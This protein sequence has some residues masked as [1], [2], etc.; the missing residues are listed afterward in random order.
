MK[1][2][3]FV[4]F[5]MLQIRVYSQITVEKMVFDEVNKNRSLFGL[6]NVIP[7]YSLDLAAKHHTKWMSLVGFSNIKKLMEIGISGGNGSHYESIDVPNFSELLT[8]Q[9]RFIK[10]NK[11]NNITYSSEICSMTR[12]TDSSNPIL[13]RYLSNSKLAKNIVEK[14]LKSIEHREEILS[15]FNGDIYIGI[16]VIVKDEI[17]YTTICFVGKQ[18]DIYCK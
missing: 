7:D 1:K 6:S 5:L 4:A 10:F 2:I 17:A 18:Q 3:I 13:N 8:P 11:I 9:D 14:F 16:S 12:A 15:E